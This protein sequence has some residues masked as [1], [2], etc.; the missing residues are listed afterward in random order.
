MNSFVVR[1]ETLPLVIEIMKYGE[2]VIEY[3]KLG[4]LVI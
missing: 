3:N 1:R 2:V 4:L